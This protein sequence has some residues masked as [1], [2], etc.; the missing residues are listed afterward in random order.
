MIIHLYFSNTP[1]LSDR[2]IL[3]SFISHIKRFCDSSTSSLKSLTLLFSL[4]CRSSNLFSEQRNIDN[5]IN[6]NYDIFTLKKKLLSFTRSNLTTKELA[7]YVL[8]KVS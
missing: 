6:V 3:S 4:L 8:N 1:T 5:F 7:K 2:L